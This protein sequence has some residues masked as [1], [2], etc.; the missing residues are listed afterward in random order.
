MPISNEENRRFEELMDTL[1]DVKERVNKQVENKAY[2]VKL[3]P[4][5]LITIIIALMGLTVFSVTISS[6][7]LGV[8]AFMGMTFTASELSKIF[9][10]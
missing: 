4:F 6:I 5:I 1:V 3:R 2:F 10:K 7:P 8:I 9:W